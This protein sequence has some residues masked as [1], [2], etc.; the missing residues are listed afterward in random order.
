[1]GPRNDEGVKK[2]IGQWP[3]VTPHVSRLTSYILPATGYCLL[4]TFLILGCASAPLIED[5]HSDIAWPPPPEKA[6]I[7][8]LKAISKT[9]DLVRTEKG[10]WLKRA[11][12]F[13]T[14]EGSE[15]ALVAPYGVTA[16]K[17]GNVFV[18]DR[19]TGEI[20]SFNLRSGKSSSLFFDTE[21]PEDYPIGIGIAKN[22]YVTYPNSGL[23]R[24]FSGKGAMAAEFG[25]DADLKRP[26]GIAI[27]E[28]NGRVYVVD[29]LGHDIKVFN[30]EGKPLFTFGKRGEKDGEFNFPTHIFVAND[31]TVYVTDELNFRVQAFTPD[32]NFIFKFG[33]IGTVPG[34]IQSPKGVAVDSDGNIYIADAMADSIQVFNR[35]GGLLLLFGGNGSEDGQFEGPAGMFIDK[36]DRIYITDLYNRRV[37]V[38]QYLKD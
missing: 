27:N 25:K 28:G 14:G 11:W 7:R 26:T 10:D 36:D 20:L 37:Q 33:K 29:T 1:M 32:G 2:A 24:V 23:V 17:E 21:D 4:A 8:F 12:I 22:I 19:D 3:G 13:L 15:T 35:D 34:T 18:V 16:D 31:D 30:L 5:S 38:F 6:R 9:E